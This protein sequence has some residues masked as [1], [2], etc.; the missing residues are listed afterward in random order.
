RRLA[1]AGGARALR[2][3][4]AAGHRGGRVRRAELRD[5]RRDLLGAGPA[6]LRRTPSC[7]L[8]AGHEKS[9][10]GAPAFE[11][12]LAG[13]GLRAHLRWALISLVISNIETC[14]FLKISFSLPSALIMV[15]LAGSCSLLAL[16]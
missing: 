15:R 10:C 4:D 11:A 6:R 13:C 8:N 14:G 1:L 16:M 7:T 9:R 3:R 12:A 5:R 2:G